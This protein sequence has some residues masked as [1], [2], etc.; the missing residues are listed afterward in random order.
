VGLGLAKFI[1]SGSHCLTLEKVFPL[2]KYISHTYPLSFVLVKSQSHRTMDA[3]FLLRW[4]FRGGTRTG[5][6]SFVGVTL[7]FI[8]EGVPPVEIHF[9]CILIEFCTSL[10]PISQDYG[11]VIPPKIKIPRLDLDWQN[12]CCQGHIAWHWSRCSPCQNSFLMHTYWLLYKSNTNHT[13]QW[14]RDSC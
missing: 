13:G 1:L 11:C 4:R 7:P 5:K 10:I 12:F 6:I 3:W 9:S 2:S 14:M 8:G